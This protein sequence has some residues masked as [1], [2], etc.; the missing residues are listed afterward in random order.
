MEK[1]TA[2][3]IFNEAGKVH[4]RLVELGIDDLDAGEVVI[5]AA[6]SSVNYKDALAATGAGRI[7]RRFPCVGGI[8]CAGWV[9]SSSDARFREGD[10]V[11]CTSYD[12]GV[13][14]D[15]GYSGYLR[16][17]ADWVVPLPAGLSLFEAMALGTA[18]YTAGLGIHLMEHDGLR[19]EGGKVLVNGATG[20]VAS[21]AID[22]LAGRGYEVSALTGKMTEEAY[23]RQLGATEVLDRNGLEMGTKPLERALWAG[24]VDSVGGEQLAWLTRTV[25]EWGVIASIG[26]AGGV[27]LE[28]TVMPFILRGIKLLGVDSATTPMALRAHIWGRLAT[29]L[30]PRHLSAMTRAVGLQELGPVFEGIVAG[31]QRGRTVVQLAGE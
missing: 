25:K 15:G 28:T 4:S 22:L 13:A 3:R 31:N 9:V 19:P 14:H 17:P 10:P 29:D 2:L 27:K 18:G 21:I 8:D 24:A 7:I 11:I 6:Y 20:G 12:L 1:F 23:L 26:L 30:R 5:R 16:V